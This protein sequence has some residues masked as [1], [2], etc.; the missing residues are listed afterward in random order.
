MAKFTK[1]PLDQLVYTQRFGGWPENYKRYG[2]IGHNGVDFRTKFPDSPIGRREV[3]AVMDG[4]VKEI[5]TDPKVGY[6]I[7]VRLTHADKSETIYAHFHSVK[8]ELGQDV[9]AGVVLGISDD[10][11]ASKGAHLHFGYRPPKPNF[12]NGYKGYIDPEPFFIK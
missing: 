2:M 6:G 4:R 3:Y 9:K 8:V 7:F 5:G 1:N 12:N 10:T 11:G